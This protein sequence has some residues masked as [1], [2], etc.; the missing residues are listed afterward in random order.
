MSR[1]FV[2]VGTQVAIDRA[3]TEARGRVRQESRV[4]ECEFP[5]AAT[6]RDIAHG[7]GVVPT[8][9]IILLQSGGLV[10][11]KQVSLWTAEIAYLSAT[12]PHTRARFYFVVTEAPHVLA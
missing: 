8:G 3:L 6:A 5:L 12:A 7:M 1:P 2:D 9:V 10:A 4:F 11:A